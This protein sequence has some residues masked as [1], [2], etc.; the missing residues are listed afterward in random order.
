MQHTGKWSARCRHKSKTRRNN[1]NPPATVCTVSI[2]VGSKDLLQTALVFHC[3]KCCN[4]KNVVFLFKKHRYVLVQSCIMKALVSRHWFCYLLPQ[5]SRLS[6]GSR[7]TLCRFCVYQKTRRPQ[8]AH[9]SFAGLMNQKTKVPT[10]CAPCIFCLT[11]SIHTLIRTHA[12]G[13]ER[14]SRKSVDLR[15]D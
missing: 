1:T 11:F 12:H 13:Q 14:Q 10:F 15:V 4:R 7:V 9:K 8:R 3:W 2:H 6:A 5:R